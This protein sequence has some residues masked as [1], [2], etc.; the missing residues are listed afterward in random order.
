MKSYLGISAVLLLLACNDK[1]T[2]SSQAITTTA[3]S[4]NASTTSAP[5]ATPSATIYAAVPDGPAPTNVE[6]YYDHPITDDELKGKTLREY[7]LMRNVIHARA[8][9]PFHKRWIRSYFD[10]QAWYHPAEET[11]YSRLS[12]LDLANAKKIA[13]A[14][15]AVTHDELIER[16]AGIAKRVEDGS[17]TAADKTELELVGKRL[18]EGLGS[19]APPSLLINLF[20]LDNVVNEADV[21]NFSDREL[22]LLRNTIYA[23]RGRAFR[24][25][26]LQNYFGATEWYSV[27]ANFKESLMT[28]TDRVNI[29]LFKSIED[30]RKGERRGRDKLADE[31]AKRWDSWQVYA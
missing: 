26:D 24:S 31:A 28:H 7:S 2:P 20:R 8:R 14:E 23:R 3:S 13:S 9:H 12:D 25:K 4:V 11:D 15:A 5:S 16:R 6:F 19:G 22:R 1:P 17:V 10:A 27:N 21:K 30:S 18:G 29:R